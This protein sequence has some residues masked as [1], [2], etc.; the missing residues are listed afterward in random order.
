MGADAY[1]SILTGIFFLFIIGSTFFINYKV[2][3]NKKHKNIK[4]EESADESKDES[5]STLEES[6]K[7]EVV[8]DG[9]KTEVAE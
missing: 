5:L 3:I 2:V 8:L 1:S 9:P 6:S 7:E 4:V